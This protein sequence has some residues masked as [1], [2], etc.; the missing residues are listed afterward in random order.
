MTGGDGAMKAERLHAAHHRKEATAS[1]IAGAYI[2]HGVPCAN[3]QVFARSREASNG[4][5]QYRPGSLANGVTAGKPGGTPVYL[6]ECQS[7]L[8]DLH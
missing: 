7:M 8:G 2:A 3:V 6:T 1:L 4:N 5:N